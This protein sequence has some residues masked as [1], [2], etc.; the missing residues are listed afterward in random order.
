[1]SKS[2][3]DLPPLPSDAG[4]PDPDPSVAIFARLADEYGDL[5][6]CSECARED[7]EPDRRGLL[8]ACARHDGS[9]DSDDRDCWRCVSDFED[10]GHGTGDTDTRL[11]LDGGL[12]GWLCRTHALNTFGDADCAESAH[13]AAMASRDYERECERAVF[14]ALAEERGS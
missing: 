12:M 6:E 11:Y 5:D 1:M 8:G 10:G 2:L 13:R 4:P 7:V 14:E 9:G 3:F